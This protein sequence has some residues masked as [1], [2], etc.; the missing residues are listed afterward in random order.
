MATRLYMDLSV[1]NPHLYQGPS[2]RLPLDWSNNWENFLF[3]GRLF[4]LVNGRIF[5]S[6]DIE[7]HNHVYGDIYI[8]MYNV[9][10]DNAVIR[11][12]SRYF[13]YH[14]DTDVLLEFIHT[15]PTLD[16]FLY[17]ARQ[18]G[19]PLSRHTL[20][21]FVE[22]KMD[23]TPDNYYDEVDRWDEELKRVRAAH[24]LMGSRLE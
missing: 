13:V 6:L 10:S 23:V 21:P 9:Q 14:F 15:Y 19:G 18:W 12:G 7:L 3:C 24:A 5:K 20:T 4:P 16:A 2:E 8:I 11:I 1:P 22:V 17:L